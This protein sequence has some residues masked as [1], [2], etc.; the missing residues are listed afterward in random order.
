MRIHLFLPP[1]KRPLRAL[2]DYLAEPELAPLRTRM[3]RRS[4]PLALS[5]GFSLTGLP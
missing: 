3:M 1:H 2:S 4:F 5:A